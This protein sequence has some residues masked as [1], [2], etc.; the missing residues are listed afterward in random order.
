ME[1]TYSCH[2]HTLHAARQSPT[3][4]T[5]LA[6]TAVPRNSVAVSAMRASSSDGTHCVHAWKMTQSKPTQW[7]QMFECG[8]V[9]AVCAPGITVVGA[10][11]QQ[12]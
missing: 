12:V 6:S 2:V 7:A 1:A 9:A 11:M 10:G 8:G 3:A 4:S 5:P